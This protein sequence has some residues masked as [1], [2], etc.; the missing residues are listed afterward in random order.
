[1]DSQ[2]ATKVMLVDDE[3]DFID[4]LS[5]RL[6]ARG[7]KVIAVTSGKEALVKTDDRPRKTG[8]EMACFFGHFS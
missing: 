7:L 5:Q 4:I 2:L 6:Q 3:K 8:F 1:M